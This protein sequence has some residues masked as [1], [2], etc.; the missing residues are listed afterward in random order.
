MACRMGWSQSDPPGRTQAHT[1]CAD[2]EQVDPHVQGGNQ[3]GRS[4][5]LS[6][7]TTHVPAMSSEEE[8]SFYTMRGVLGGDGVEGSWTRG[9]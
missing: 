4:Q 8:Q 3:P 6:P 5:R 9:S 2:R 1:G 7:R